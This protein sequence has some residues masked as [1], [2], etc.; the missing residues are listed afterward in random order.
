MMKNSI[1]LLLVCLTVIFSSYVSAEQYDLNYYINIFKHK[2]Y[3]EQK[4]AASTLQ[5]SGLSDERLFDQIQENLE[6]LTNKGVS[7]KTTDY[8]SWM[9]KA[10]GFSGNEKYREFIAMYQ[11]KTYSSKIHKYA[12]QSLTLIDKYKDLNPIIN[13]KSNFNANESLIDNRLHNMIISDQYELKRMAAKR[14]HYDHK[15]TPYL[16]NSLSQQIQNNYKNIAD[17][18]LVIDANA[19]MLKALAGS[20]NIEYKTLVTEVSKNSNNGKLKRSARKNLSYFK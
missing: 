3:N 18:R 19:W 4:S 17:D 20:N 14:I 12:R 1:K 16:L 2:N 7:N 13:D 15:Y 9:L 10:L 11:T 5:W 8:A 6:E